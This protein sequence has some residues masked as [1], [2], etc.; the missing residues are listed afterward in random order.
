MRFRIEFSL[1]LF[2]VLVHYGSLFKEEIPSLSPKEHRKNTNVKRG[3]GY[4]SFR[5]GARMVQKKKRT[6]HKTAI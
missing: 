3:D 5:L 4:V 6:V 1:L 2:D